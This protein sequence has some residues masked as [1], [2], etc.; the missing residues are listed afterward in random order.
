MKKLLL[1]IVLTLLTASASFAQVVHDGTS[2]VTCSQGTPSMSVSCTSKTTT[3]SN[4]IGIFA[5]VVS[6]AP[7]TLTPEWGSGNTMSDFGSATN[8]TDGREA[9][10]WYIYA[11]ATA[12]TT[13]SLTTGNNATM[14]CSASSFNGAHQSSQTNS[15]AQNAS[16]T[17]DPAS[18][19]CTAGD[20]EF[21]VDVLYF[22]GAATPPSST[23]ATQNTGSPTDQGS[24]FGG[25]SRQDG[26]NANSDLMSWTLT[27]PTRWTQV[28]NKILTTGGGGGGS[29]RTSVLTL[30]VGK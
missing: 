16:G 5:C 28:C 7:G 14:V 3:G 29:S 8:A 9:H 2:D 18:V 23:T 21:I 26:N 24:W 19:T 25:A 27:T 10:L 13:V 6:N 30:G 1:A 11:P 4:R 20:D 12:S 15:T 17:T 22:L